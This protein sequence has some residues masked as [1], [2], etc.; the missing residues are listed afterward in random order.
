[1]TLG[2][3]LLSSLSSGVITQDEVDWVTSHQYCFNREEVASALR[4]GRLIDTGDVNLGC[5]LPLSVR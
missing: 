3:V 5:R 4:L 1:M 2:E